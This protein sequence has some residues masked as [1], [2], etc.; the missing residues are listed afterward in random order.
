ME[1]EKPDTASTVR[2]FADKGVETARSAVEYLLNT[3]QSAAQA[4]QSESRSKGPEGASVEKGFEFAKENVTAIFD[5]A[6]KLVRTPD[7][8][9]AA[10]L[11][12][13]FIK[14]RA[15]VVNK[16]LEELRTSPPPAEGAAPTAPPEGAAPKTAKPKRPSEGGSEGGTG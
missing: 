16:Q 5:F 6:Q 10:Q 2:D 3:A 8:K 15:V 11:N 4:V 9:Q 1:R 14:S 12:A 13:D 7:L